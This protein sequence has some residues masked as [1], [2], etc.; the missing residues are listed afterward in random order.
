MPR[1]FRAVL[2]AGAL[3]LPL[4]A[5]PAGAEDDPVVA[6]VNDSEVHLSDLED[7]K[8]SL[9]QLQQ[10]P[11]G[12]I[13]GDLL[14]QAIANTAVAEKALAEKVNEEPEVTER[15][16]EIERQLAGRVWIDRQLEARITEEMIQ[17]RFEAYKKN[18]PPA[19]E[20]KARHILVE[21]EADARALI[22]ELNGGAD[23]ATL[24]EEHSTGPS[25]SRGGD[26]GFFGQG[27]MVPEFAA[28]AF[29]LEPGQF[30]G[31]PV[32]TQFGWHV[33]KVDERRM[34]EPPKLDNRLRAR[35]K[36]ELTGQVY[37]D[38]VAELVE[39][40]KVERLDPP[41]GLAQ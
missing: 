33:I 35:I 40:A 25:A 8:G 21:T 22:E 41:E 4:A 14:E 37:R 6:R 16:A 18:N 30:T 32:K 20:V 28:A 10:V 39:A 7:L 17:E 13:Y 2:L 34:S 38:V 19:P 15:L 9:P 23:F 27:E 36:G 1:S 24:A 31:E 12:Q 3:A 11:M 26:L 5:Q 29:A